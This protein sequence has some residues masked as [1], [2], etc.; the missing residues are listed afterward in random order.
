MP[1]RQKRYEVKMGYSIQ[2]KTK[3]AH[4]STIWDK[5]STCLEEVTVTAL[6]M[7]KSW[8]HNSFKTSSTIIAG[9]NICGLK[10]NGRSRKGSKT[11]PKPQELVHKLYDSFYVWQLNSKVWKWDWAPLIKFQFYRIVNVLS[12]PFPNLRIELPNIVWRYS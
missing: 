2:R 12:I 1:C 6:I 11:N 10:I 3:Y 5:K 7:P 9:L 8:L 4:N